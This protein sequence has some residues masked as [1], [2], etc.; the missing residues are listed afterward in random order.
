MDAGARRALLPLVCQQWRDIL[1]QPT[2]LWTHLDIDFASEAFSDEEH[3]GQVCY[4]PVGYLKGHRIHW[5]QL[6]TRHFTFH[7]E[8]GTGGMPGRRSWGDR[9]C[10]FQAQCYRVSCQCQTFQS[11]EQETSEHLPLCSMLVCEQCK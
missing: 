10:S 8:Q 1:S 6:H 9:L 4:V 7:I 2:S 3:P 5:G 11:A